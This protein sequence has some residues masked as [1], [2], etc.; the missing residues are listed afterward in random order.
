I[1]LETEQIVD[2]VEALLALGPVDAADID[3]LLEQAARI[4]TQEGQQR[5][6]LVWRRLK[7]QL[8]QPYIRGNDRASGR[9]LDVLAEFLKGFAHRTIVPV[10]R[11]FFWSCSTP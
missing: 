4:V 3:Q 10:R 1:V 5:D 7:H 11:T 8:A 9:L 6:Q 2:D